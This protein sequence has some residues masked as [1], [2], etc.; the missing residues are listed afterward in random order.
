MAKWTRCPSIGMF[1]TGRP[2]QAQSRRSQRVWTYT[3][4]EWPHAVERH[5]FVVPRGMEILRYDSPEQ[6]ADLFC[7]TIGI[8]WDIVEEIGNGNSASVFH[9]S[10]DRAHAAIKIY[11]PRFFHGRRAIVETRRVSDQMSLMGHGH[12]NLIDFFEAGELKDTCYLLMEYL[13]W[14]SLD[15][16]IGTIDRSLIAC[17]IAQIAC[18]ARYLDARGFVHRDIKPA[19]ILVSDDQLDVKLLDLGVIRPISTRDNDAGT[20]D[21]YALPFLATAQYSSPAYLFR[22]GPP[23]S[24]MWRALTFYQLGAVLHDM[25]TEV[26]LF[27]SEVRTQNRYRVAAAVLL[28]DPAARAPD[29]P[30]RLVTLARNCLVKEDDTRLSRVSWDSFRE[31]QQFDLNQLRRRL[32]L[33]VTIR[34]N[35]L[36]RRKHEL[37]KVRLDRGRDVLVD[38]VRH[39]FRKE[40]LPQARQEDLD[41]GSRSRGIAYGFRPRGSSQSGVELYYVLQLVMMDEYS[42][43]VD[44]LLSSYLIRSE[45]ERGTDRDGRVIWSTRLDDLEKED[46]ELIMV[47]TE[48]FIRDY[49]AADERIGQ[50][51]EGTDMTWRISGI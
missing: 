1:R 4:I 39:V 50:F 28:T 30:P 18:A 11:H 51:E 7:N 12:P 25:L 3:R 38:L 27:A 48:N 32:G 35:N 49:A 17:L 8:G 47:L 6:Y 43:R 24:E 5:G 15:K 34:G 26:P 44:V 46:E 20:D 19:N 45:E 41:R 36:N 21:G 23:T 37:L 9:L 42:D 22:D 13:P 10:S 14:K 40:G 29:V 16:H 33:E 2:V 31:E